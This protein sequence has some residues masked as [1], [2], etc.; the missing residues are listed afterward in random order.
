MS[1][2]ERTFLI[3]YLMASISITSIM[4]QY[5]KAVNYQSPPIIY[6]I[7][8]VGWPVLGFIFT[9]ATLFGADFTKVKDNSFSITKDGER[10]WINRS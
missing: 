1:N 10:Q 4:V 6:G 5:D 2:A 7:V 3:V 9:A 8:F